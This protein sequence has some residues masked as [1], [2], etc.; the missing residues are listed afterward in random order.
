MARRGALPRSNPGLDHRDAD[1][2]QPRLHVAKHRLIPVSADNGSARAGKLR[3]RPCG[4]G[5]RVEAVVCQEMRLGEP[6]AD[7]R[8]RPEAV[9]G[10]ELRIPADTVV[11]AIGQEPRS[12]LLSWIDGIELDGGRV[13]VDERG[14]TANPRYFAAGDAAAVQVQNSLQL[15]PAEP[16]PG[17]PPTVVGEA[18]HVGHAGARAPPSRSLPK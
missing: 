18:E 12:T 10:S 14:C 16:H 5:G 2:P 11:K 3:R 7:G 13:P 9:E 4:A 1:L 17:R 15:A 6:D 8:R